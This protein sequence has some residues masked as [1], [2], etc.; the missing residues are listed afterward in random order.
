[1]FV[2][3]GQYPIAFGVNGSIGHDGVNVGVELQ[4]LAPGVEH[5]EESALAADV[6]W[7][8]EKDLQGVCAGSEK[9]AVE[10]LSVIAEDVVEFL[11]EGKDEVEVA[12][13]E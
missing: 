9:Q 2:F 12:D 4:A 11:C 5:A 7:V 10:L 3:S 13:G 6:F 1:M 8:F